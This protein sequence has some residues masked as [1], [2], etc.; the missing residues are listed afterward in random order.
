MGFLLGSG[1]LGVEAVTANFPSRFGNIDVNFHMSFL[2]MDI[3]ELSGIRNTVGGADNAAVTPKEALAG[4]VLFLA[5]GCEGKRVHLGSNV[6]KG[7]VFINPE[8]SKLCDIRHTDLVKVAAEVGGCSEVKT[9]GCVMIIDGKV[10]D[11]RIVAIEDE[12]PMGEELVMRIKDLISDEVREV[13]KQH[14]SVAMTPE[15]IAEK[16]SFEQNSI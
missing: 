15:V 16:F 2:K 13:P 9:T 5:Y 6:S 1:A 8:A 7:G 14:V 11:T 12:V 4:K 3:H 10:I